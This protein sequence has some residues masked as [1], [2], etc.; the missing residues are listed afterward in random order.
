MVMCPWTFSI[1]PSMADI[2]EDFPEPTVPTTA[3]NWPGIMSRFTLKKR[4]VLEGNGSGVFESR[5]SHFSD[6]PQEKQ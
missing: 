4:N 2:K 5:S 6:S 1:S 3:T